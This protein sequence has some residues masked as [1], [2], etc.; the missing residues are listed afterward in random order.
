MD[1]LPAC[2]SVYYIHDWCPLRPE[3]GVRSPK[4]GVPDGGEL[5]CGCPRTFT[6]TPNLFLCCFVCVFLP[7]PGTEQQ[8]DHHHV[9][10]VMHPAVLGLPCSMGSPSTLCQLTRRTTDSHQ[11]REVCPA[12]TLVQ[13]M[14]V[15]DPPDFDTKPILHRAECSRFRSSDQ[16]FSFSLC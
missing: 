7:N 1:V 2:M 4:T 9:S 14:L 10:P 8:T 15:I 11:H 13:E 12:A 16:K 6:N 5:P 3:K